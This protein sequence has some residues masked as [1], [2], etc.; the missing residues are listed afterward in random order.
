MTRCG[1]RRDRLI[2]LSFALVGFLT[3]SGTALAQSVDQPRP[4]NPAYASPAL[5]ELVAAMSRDNGE[6]PP[7]LM[8]F[9]AH[10]ESE[11]ALVLR[12]PAPREGVA[13]E[14]GSSSSVPERVVQVD[15]IA[16]ELYWQHSGQ[17]QQ[18]VVGSRTRAIGASVSSLSYF[19]RPWVVPL[20]YGNRLQVLIGNEATVATGIARPEAVP[21]NRLTDASLPAVHPFAEDRDEFYTFAG[22]D[23][24]AVLHLN[25][26]SIPVSRI[27]VEPR[28]TGRQRL[29]MFRGEIDV[30]AARHQIIRMH[31]QFFVYRSTPSLFRKIV[32]VGLQSVAFA[33]LENGEFNG[34]YWLPTRQRLE[35]QVRSRFAGDLGP[36]VRVLTTVNR[37]EISG[38]SA[39]HA[40]DEG[41]V[42]PALAAHLSVAPRD[43]L[44]Q[45]SAWSAEIGTSTTNARSDDFDD[46]A[47]ESWKSTGARRID[48]RAERVSDIARFNRVEGLFLG[49]AAVM[50]FRDAVPGLDIGANGGWA[51]REATARGAIWSRLA[52][53]QTTFTARIGRYLA[54]TN[55]FAPLI[56]SDQS[57]GA[58][59]ATVDDA[60]YVDRR[61]A[62]V[63]VSKALSLPGN[64]EIRLE[65]GVGGDRPERTRVRYGLIHFDSTFRSNR[66]VSR[67]TYARTVAAIAVHPNVTG[68]F[69]EPG[70]GASAWY[71][72][73]DGQLNWQRIEMRTAARHVHGDWSYAARLDAAALF[74]KQILPQQVI[75]F[76]GAEGLPG[77]AYKE[78]G[79]DRA[80]LAHAGMTYHFPVLRAPIRFGA[81][82]GPLSRIY[83][84]GL[85]PALSVSV[86]SGWS[87][88]SA[89]A[90]RRTLLLFGMRTDSVT[91]TM[92]PATRPTGVP[93]TSVGVSASAF[94][95]ALGITIG[96]QIGH[97][98]AFGRWQLSF[99]AGATY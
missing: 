68:E 92:I 47:P 9:H 38:D 23:T 40:E 58:L 96:R 57:G 46:V 78:F 44:E 41:P 8:K 74:T 33:D 45:F 97:G 19:T 10:A 39:R 27:F 4:G 67:G 55:D 48:I 93:R 70:V 43:S 22:G 63:S 64:P 69:L 3:H 16:S 72:R 62:T 76:G 82:S 86:Q 59:L 99:G 90:T 95:G 60:D 56:G 94:G 32:A 28:R 52:R 98:T 36:I 21:R 85:T 75:E 26:R 29:L 30:D 83:F 11:V 91:H 17:F 20:L 12:S 87:Q 5:R 13:A 71:E 42:A 35:L 14:T 80:V 1:R 89:P 6:V 15:Q 2:C 34:H 37:Y 77:Y 61:L 65:A 51:F 53:Q 24:V 7:S 18:H 79:G 88:A 54:S 73:G 66:V 84:P 31:G 50:R 81:W 49:G 25:G